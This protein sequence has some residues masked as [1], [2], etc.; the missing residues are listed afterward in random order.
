MTISTSLTF[1]KPTYIWNSVDVP[2]SQKRAECVSTVCIPI[3][4]DCKFFKKCSSSGRSHQTLRDPSDLQHGRLTGPCSLPRARSSTTKLA[5]CLLTFLSL[6]RPFVSLVSLS[7]PH[8]STKHL[9]T[10]VLVSQL[11]NSCIS[12]TILAPNTSDRY[13]REVSL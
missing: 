13:W 8:L 3:P 1:K 10:D 12:A 7:L 9:T 6:L 5:E 11:K 2:P 4:S